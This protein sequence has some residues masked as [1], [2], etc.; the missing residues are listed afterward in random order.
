MRFLLFISFVGVLIAPNVGYAQVPT[1]DPLGTSQTATETGN[2]A[3]NV[4]EGATQVSQYQK[5]MAAIG[6]YK[7]TVSGYMSKVNDYKKKALEQKA[8]MDKARAD[9]MAYKAEAMAYKKQI[10]EGVETAKSA[11]GMAKGMIDKAKDTVN[12]VKSQ[13][14]G[15]VNDA[16]NKAT[17]AV[18]GAT[19]DVNSLKSGSNGGGSE[20]ASVDDGKTSAENSQQG[21]TSDSAGQQGD[22]GESTEQYASSGETTSNGIVDTPSAEPTRRPIITGEAG[23]SDSALST[24]ATSETAAVAEKSAAAMVER[25][26][27]EPTAAITAE[28]IS[29]EGAAKIK[30]DG[31]ISEQAATVKSAAN[32]SEAKILD[33]ATVKTEQSTVQEMKAQRSEKLRAEKRAKAVDKARLL[34]EETEKTILEKQIQPLE[35]KNNKPRR[36][37]FKTSQ[38]HGNIRTLIPLAFASAELTEDFSGGEAMDNLLIIP[39][40]IGMFCGVDISNAAEQVGAMDTC[41]KKVNDLRYSKI[42]EQEKTINTFS[43]P[44]DEISTADRDQAL[45][46]MFDGYAELMA[47]AYLEALSTYND[48]LTYK[49]NSLDPILNQVYSNKTGESWP[50]LLSMNIELSDRVNVL[51]KLWAR[52][53]QI[54]TYQAYMYSGIRTSDEETTKP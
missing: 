20:E 19:G 11:P 17:S 38:G 45:Q 43:G 39:A 7:E 15:M 42:G 33:Q 34:K 1:T 35:L 32:V 29:L 48:S 13:A 50:S 44:K 25:V 5:T 12:S 4:A 51:N 23:Q 41:L 27:K 53:L 37:T 8:K 31:I 16:K 9:F 24:V 26:A 54:N 18:N 22:V 14:E 46:E 3:N 21:A 6:T 36:A 2:T 52:L 49:E 30:A 10:E 47:S 28:S 40:K